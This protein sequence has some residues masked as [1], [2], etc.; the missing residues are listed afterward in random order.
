MFRLRNWLAALVAGAAFAGPAMADGHLEA[1]VVARQSVMRL[2]VHN[3]SLLGGMAQG[4]IEYDAETA[5]RA[6]EALAL[7]ARIDQSRM[8]P[9]GSDNGTLGNM[10][11]AKPEIWGIAS[12]VGAKYSA[13]QD[14][15]AA[16]A[17]VAADDLAALQGAIGAVGGACSACHKAYRGPKP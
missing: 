8:W 12:D 17:K 16:L 10:T 4:K 13:L 14:A 2:Y 7:V 1:A 3:I 11:R 6:A 15:T 5:G 9:M